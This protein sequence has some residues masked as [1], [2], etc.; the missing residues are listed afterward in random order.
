MPEAEFDVVCSNCRTELTV[1]SEMKGQQSSCPNCHVTIRLM[2]KLELKR[3]VVTQQPAQQSVTLKCPGCGVVMLPTAVICTGCGLDLRTGQRFTQS[4]VGQTN[5]EEKPT[6][7]T[8]KFGVGAILITVVVVYLACVGSDI[9]RES[10][11]N[12]ESTIVADSETAYT[13]TRQIIRERVPDPS[14]LTFK[15]YTLIDSAPPRYLLKVKF[16]CPNKFGAIVW[17]YAL[18]SITLIGDGEF[19]YDHN[20]GFVSFASEEEVDEALDMFKSANGWKKPN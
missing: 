9:R 16:T 14:R 8:L 15:N 10:E 20:F 3:V 1:P 4:S 13:C 11:G 7:S 12:A 6:Y 18:S 17:G 19:K 2:P 5:V